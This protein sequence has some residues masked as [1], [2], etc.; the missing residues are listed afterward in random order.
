MT[1][2]SN[3]SPGLVL[4]FSFTFPFRRPTGT[5]HLFDDGR[6]E[7]RGFGVVHPTSSTHG[8]VATGRVQRALALADRVLA[9]QRG[10]TFYDSDPSHALD[11]ELYVDGTQRPAEF[12]WERISRYDTHYDPVVGDNAMADFD[13]LVALLEEFERASR[14]NAP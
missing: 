8:R 6:V 12:R 13:A 3:T 5:I 14:T 10:P 2:N 1:V 9:A 11:L 7:N 4:R